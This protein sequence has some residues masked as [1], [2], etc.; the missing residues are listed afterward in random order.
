MLVIVIIGMIMKATC[1]TMEAYVAGHTLFWVGH[2]GLMYVIDI[3]L[4]DMTTLKNRMLMFTLNGTPQIASTFA[5]PR[6]ADLFYNN[7][8]FRWAF[9]AFAIIMFGA[10][11]PVMAIMLYMQRKAYQ[12]GALEKTVS[13]RKWWQ[14]V[15]HYFI[16]FDGKPCP[17]LLPLSN[18]LMSGFVSK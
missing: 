9:G 10:C 17:G 2:L 3:M 7:L 1:Q 4:A 12:T 18:I 6:I 13:N 8:N 5:G 11:I 15:R 14:S 16:E